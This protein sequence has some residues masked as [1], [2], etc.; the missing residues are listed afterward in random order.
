MTVA[1]AAKS[2][3]VP[4]GL[5]EGGRVTKPIKKGELLNSSNV[6]VDRTSRIYALKHA[7]NDMLRDAAVL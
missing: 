5:L 1:D 7:Q 4:C 2:S 3:A 6:E